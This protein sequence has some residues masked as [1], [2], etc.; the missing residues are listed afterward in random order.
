MKSLSKLVFIVL[1]LCFGATTLY[2]SDN[3]SY[4]EKR[5]EFYGTIEQLPD[6]LY[7]V[8]VVDGRQIS[9]TPSTKIEQ[10]Y[11]RVSIGAAVEVEGA[12]EGQNFQAYEIE[13][14]RKGRSSSDSGISY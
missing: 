6:G 7:G 9:V 14:S 12:Y 5:G 8:W 2:A 1:L 10:E 13:V 3:D 4:R 11:G